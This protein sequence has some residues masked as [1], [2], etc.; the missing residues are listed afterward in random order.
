MEV[1]KVM[2]KYIK[3]KVYSS[4]QRIMSKRKHQLAS[5]AAKVGRETDY[6]DLLEILWRTIGSGG[7]A[8]APRVVEAPLRAMAAG[9][10]NSIARRSGLHLAAGRQGRR[11]ALEGRS[12]G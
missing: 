10:R 8:C 11:C 12:R 3:Y 1:G 2:P 9:W 5:R 4:P 6:A 7:D